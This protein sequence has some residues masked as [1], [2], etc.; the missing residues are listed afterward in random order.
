MMLTP[1]LYDDSITPYD[2]LQSMISAADGHLKESLTRFS[3]I[4]PR[5]D[6]DFGF[7]VYEYRENLAMVASEPEIEDINYYDVTIK[8]KF[9][10]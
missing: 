4:F 10:N 6:A 3:T 8:M 2:Y 1:N 9:W 7:N 5:F